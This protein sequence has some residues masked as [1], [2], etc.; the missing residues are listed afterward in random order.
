MTRL[1]TSPLRAALVALAGLLA[2]CSGGG[3]GTAG[4]VDS[5]Q[6]REALK[7]A[8][9]GWKKGVTP[10]SFS[11]ASPPMTVQDMDW[12]AGAKLVDYRLADDG[13]EFGVNLH[14]PVALTLRTLQ[15][16]EVKKSV[17]YVVGTSP[18]VTVFRGL[19]SAG[20]RGGPDGRRVRRDD[21]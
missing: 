7:T 16:K 21:P 18:I 17:S 10:E 9:D 2:G 6:A 3:G 14:V 20:S 13:K 11:T 1:R 8:L 15:G 19:H 4:P 12:M 5:A